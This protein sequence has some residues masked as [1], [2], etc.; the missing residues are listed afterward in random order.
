MTAYLGMKYLRNKLISKRPRN[1]EKYLY[2]EMKNTM[3]DFNITMPKEFI[4]LK[5]CLGWSAKAVDSIANRLSFREFSNDNF[6]INEIYQLNNPDVLFDSAIISALITSCSFIYIS[7]DIS[8]FPRMQVIDGR[9]A[10]GII[11]PITYML[12]EGYAVLERNIHDEPVKE[13]YFIKEGTWFYEKDKAPYFISSKAPYP[14]LVPVIFRPDPKRP[15]GHS[16]I[17]RACIGIQ[18]SAMRTLKRSEVSAEF[19]SFP[20]KYVLGLSPDAEALDKWRATVSTMLQLDKDE[21]GDSPT[22]GQFEQQ[23][24]APYVEQLKMFASLFAGETGL[25][26]DDLGFSTDNPSS[27]EAI[28]AQHENLRLIARKAQKTFSVGFLNAGYLAAC[29]RDNYEYDRYQIYLSKA[30]WEPLFEP[31]SSTLSVIGDGAIKINQAVPGFFDK[32]TLRDLTGIDYSE[33]AGIGKT[34]GE[35]VQ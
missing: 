6:G 23:S 29:L 3:R 11:D 30:K 13:A 18:Q 35:I 24:M 20:Q 12:S 15:F 26:L 9:N 21:D 10:T 22:V 4:W 32:D 25:T 33:N 1:E 8:G 17:S 28:K 7:N 31:D 2:Y 34:A 19:Y 14:L 5:S 16:R 27:V